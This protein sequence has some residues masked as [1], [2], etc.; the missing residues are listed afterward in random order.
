MNIHLVSSLTQEDEERT[1]PQILEAV[2]TV[3]DQLPIAYTIRL[4]TV[5]G[6]VVQHRSFSDSNS[7]EPPG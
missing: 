1:A 2:R 3:L 4:E 6:H 5:S 7:R